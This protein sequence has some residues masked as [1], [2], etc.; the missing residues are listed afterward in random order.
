MK[1]TILICVIFLMSIVLLA[2]DP[3]AVSL[4]VQGEVQLKRAE[5]FQKA[6]TGDQLQNN[7]Q[8]ESRDESYAAIKFIDGSSI[9]KLFP[10]SILKI[11]ANKENNELAKKSYLQ[12]GNMWSNVMKKTGA[13]EVETPTTVVSVKGTKFLLEVSDT[14]A[15]NVFTFDGDVIITNKRDG[16]SA[17]IKAGQKGK[18]DGTIMEVSSTEKGD[19]KPGIMATIEEDMKMLK[20]DLEN[21]DG[22][23]RTIEIQFE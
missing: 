10:N 19:I 7:D 11:Q 5:K 3:V 14:G 22:E 12:V 13:F 16:K 21:S 6:K 18:S 15:T 20:F 2:N 4:K 17:E 23:I 9:V 1:Q 8:L